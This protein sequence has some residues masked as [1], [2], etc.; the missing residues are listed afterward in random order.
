MKIPVKSLVLLATIVFSCNPRVQSNK[1]QTPDPGT[2]SKSTAEIQKIMEIDGVWS[3]GEF[4][5]NKILLKDLYPSRIPFIKINKAAKQISGN[6]SCNSF[7][8]KLMIDGDKFT[9]GEPMAMTQRFC[10]GEGESTFLGYLQRVKNF[11][12]KND[13][14]LHL[15]SGDT[16]L[17]KFTKSAITQ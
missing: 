17:M 10:T 12:L 5:N 8:G 1:K 15:Y 11:K 7:S 13:S 6:T 2:D 16:L 14:S 3:L 9:L 4:G